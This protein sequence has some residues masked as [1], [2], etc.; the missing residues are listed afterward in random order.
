[1]KRREVMVSEDKNAEVYS[2]N[3]SGIG[4][5]ELIV[6]KALKDVRKIMNCQDMRVIL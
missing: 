1:M 4:H 5:N 6:G 3:L 2:P